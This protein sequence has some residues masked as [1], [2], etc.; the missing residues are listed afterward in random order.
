M[1]TI[2]L[3]VPYAMTITVSFTWHYWFWQLVW[4]ELFII[5]HYRIVLVSW[6]LLDVYK[7]ALWVL[8]KYEARL[9]TANWKVWVYNQILF[10]TALS[11]LKGWLYKLLRCNASLWLRISHSQISLEHYFAGLPGLGQDR[12]ERTADVIY[13]QK[14]IVVIN[15][16]ILTKI[17][18]I[19]IKCIKS[20]KCN[21]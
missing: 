6:I 10:V 21:I 15:T 2:S 18:N 16:T 5:F 12:V 7:G 3:Q 19:I 8:M 11:E 4:S 1:L 14:V 13:I 20:L 9:A 17:L